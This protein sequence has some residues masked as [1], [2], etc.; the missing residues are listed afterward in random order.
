[1]SCRGRD[2]GGYSGS[3]V[4]RPVRV[5]W[6]SLRMAAG[7]CS[8]V[9]DAREAV[10]RCPVDGTTLAL[11]ERVGVEIDYVVSRSGEA[12]GEVADVVALR[13]GAELVSYRVA[14]VVPPLV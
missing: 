1:M 4:R 3:L 5:V 11:A 9:A 13:R 10:M 14:Q 7:R 6:T 12:C 2:R 8:M